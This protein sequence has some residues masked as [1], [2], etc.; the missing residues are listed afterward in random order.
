[1]R[2]ERRKGRGENIRR[3]WWD[4]RCAGLSG[5]AE[6]RPLLRRRRSIALPPPLE[7]LGYD[8]PFA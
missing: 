7:P 5:L 4:R 2:R 1:M 3:N 6:Q 8:I